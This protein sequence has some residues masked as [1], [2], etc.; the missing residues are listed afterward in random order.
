[1][2][3]DWRNHWGQGDFPFLFVQLANFMEPVDQPGT[4][5]W[6]M[7]RDAQ[8]K[9]LALSN[10]GMAVAIDIGE[11]NDVH[12][13]NKKEVGYRLALEA[14]RVAYGD[15]EIISA[16]PL[17]SDMEIAGDKIILSFTTFGSK[18]KIKNNLKLQYFSIAGSDKRFVWAEAEINGDKIV[19]WNPEIKD[20]VA[21]RYA[22][23][24]NPITANLVNSEGL[25]ASPFRTDEWDK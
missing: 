2:I 19:V 25:P 9:T 15:K 5:N 16:G 23:A 21:V 11:E 24:N 22:W 18:L 10:T 7:L 3:N 8:R 12:P 4:S 20:P 6:A 17:F 1:M 13:I 14:Q